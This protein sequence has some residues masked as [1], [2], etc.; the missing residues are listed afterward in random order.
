MLDKVRD[1]RNK[2]AHFRGDL[3]ATERGHIKYAAAWLERNLPHYLPPLEPPQTSPA[4]P[5]APL[6]P[7]A[8]AA[9]PATPRHQ[10]ADVKL[11]DDVAGEDT[12]PSGIYAALSQHLATLPTETESITLKFSQ[13]ADILKKP[14]PKSAFEYRAWW[15][16]RSRGAA[17]AGS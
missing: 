14:L 2:L 13:I 3:S 10:A 15:A 4:K 11:P 8:E 12:T 9:S 16:S 17:H 1:S 7:G 6:P 5:I